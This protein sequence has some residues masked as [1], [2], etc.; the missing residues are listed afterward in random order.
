MLPLSVS[1]I[2][3]SFLCR[4]DFGVRVGNDVLDFDCPVLADAD[5]TNYTPLSA[6]AFIPIRP[7]STP[8]ITSLSLHLRLLNGVGGAGAKRER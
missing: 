2:F 8:S 7:T 3:T 5:A 6:L 1:F 4:D